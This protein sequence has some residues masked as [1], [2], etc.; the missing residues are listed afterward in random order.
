MIER[1]DF[2]KKTLTA[3]IIISVTSTNMT[4]LFA[5]QELKK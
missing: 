3:G 2:I 1:R 4:I 5:A